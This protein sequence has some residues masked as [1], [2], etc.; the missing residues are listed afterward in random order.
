MRIDLQAFVILAMF[1][2]G[3]SPASGPEPAASEVPVRREPQP[4]MQTEARKMKQAETVIVMLGDSLTA[5]YGLSAE[6]AVPAVTERR[7]TDAG[8]DVAIIN[9]GVSGDTTAMGLARYDW[10]VSSAEPDIVVVALGANDFLGGFPAEVAKANLSK[11]ITRAQTDG[12]DVILAGLEPRWPETSET[13]EA[14][15][16]DLYPALAAEF[17]VPL[18]PGFMDGVWQEPDLLLPDGLHPNVSGVEKM[19]EGLSGF[20]KHELDQRA[21][22]D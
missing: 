21:G 19:A 20:L 16:A 5:G 13:L 3:C 22:S 11:I 10:S 6:R 12:I 9:A 1:L 14:E 8:Y 15:Y 2:A 18:Y 4:A 7:L 17:D